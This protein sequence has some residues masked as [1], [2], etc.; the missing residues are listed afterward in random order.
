MIVLLFWLR[1]T[2]VFGMHT[3]NGESLIRVTLGVYTIRNSPHTVV[4]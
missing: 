3:V 1:G 4:P 2:F